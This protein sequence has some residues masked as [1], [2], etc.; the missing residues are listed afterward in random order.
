MLI[1]DKER[2][3]SNNNPDSGLRIHFSVNSCWKY[4]YDCI[5]YG[6]AGDIILHGVERALHLILNDPAYAPE[7]EKSSVRSRKWLESQVL[8]G[9]AFVESPKK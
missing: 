6:M 9:L 2:S 8:K 5:G 7:D 3:K 4:P 1:N